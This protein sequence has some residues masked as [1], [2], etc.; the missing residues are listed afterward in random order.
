MADERETAAEAVERHVRK[1]LARISAFK[2][3]L[4]AQE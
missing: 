3:R 1:I 2:A 4:K